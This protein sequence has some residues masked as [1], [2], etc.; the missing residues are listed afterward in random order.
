MT[1]QKCEAL[2]FVQTKLRIKVT[3]YPPTPKGERFRSLIIS[4]SIF[5]IKSQTFNDKFDL[6]PPWGLGGKQLQIKN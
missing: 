3:I 5:L 1:V 4:S 2:C 6:T